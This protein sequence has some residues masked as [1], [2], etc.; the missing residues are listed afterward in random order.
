MPQV[1]WPKIEK[2]CFKEYPWYF[3]SASSGSE[4]SVCPFEG[5]NAA[6]SWRCRVS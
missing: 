5:Q 2:N 4:E 1:C 6:A 3:R